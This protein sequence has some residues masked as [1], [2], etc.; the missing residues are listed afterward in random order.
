MLKN[1]LAKFLIILQ[2]T[3]KSQYGPGLHI[4]LI[5]QLLRTLLLSLSKKGHAAET[6]KSR[7]ALYKDIP[8]GHEKIKYKSLHTMWG[9]EEAK[10]MQEDGS[11]AKRP[12]VQKPKI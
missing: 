10:R 1:Q 12:F 4:L 7:K 5:Q 8:E 3:L 11:Q 9:K 6:L 2:L